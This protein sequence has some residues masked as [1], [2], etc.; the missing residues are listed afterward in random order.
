MA[1]RLRDEFV[2]FGEELLSNVRQGALSRLDEVANNAAVAEFNHGVERAIAALFDAGLDRE[3]VVQLL[4]LIHIYMCI[5]DSCKRDFPQRPPFP[6]AQKMA[7]FGDC[8]CAA[9]L[10]IPPRTVPCERR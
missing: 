7:P 10:S 8:V 6:W 4:S 5:R 3:S 2:G 9:A 1:R